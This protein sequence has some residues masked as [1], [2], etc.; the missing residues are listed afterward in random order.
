MKN[1]SLNAFFV[2]SLIASVVGAVMLLAD[3]FGGWF[4]QTTYAGVPLDRYGSI[5][6]VTVYSPIVAVLAAAMLY[7]GYVSYVVLRSD[8]S[9]PSAVSVRRAYNSSVAAFG[10]TAALAVIFAIVMSTQDVEEWWLGG[11]FYGAAVGSVLSG[12]LLKLG[13]NK[14]AD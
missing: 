11:G 6:L 9:G 1:E 7:S 4:F 8:D 12:V 13:L 2:G 3:D 14:I 5:G 10:A